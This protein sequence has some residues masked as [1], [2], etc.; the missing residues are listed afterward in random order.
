MDQILFNGAYVQALKSFCKHCLKVTAKL[1]LKIMLLLP[2]TPK[3]T[4]IGL[5]IF[6]ITNNCN[7][8]LIFFVRQV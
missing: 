3:V 5:Q 8:Q 1:I 7:L 2:I 4:S 6:L